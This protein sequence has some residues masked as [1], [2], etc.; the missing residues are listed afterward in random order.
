MKHSTVNQDI[1]GVSPT[2][3]GIVSSLLS[4]ELKGYRPIR[5]A[6]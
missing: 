5:G 1:S 6:Y 3:N 2:S 4:P